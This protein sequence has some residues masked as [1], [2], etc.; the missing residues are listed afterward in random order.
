MRGQAPPV[1]PESRGPRA[2]AATR[3]DRREKVLEGSKA[4]SK[5]RV[6][7]L[8]ARRRSSGLPAAVGR[9]RLK[10]GRGRRFRGAPSGSVDL[11]REAAATRRPTRP[12][13]SAAAKARSG[14]EVRRARRRRGVGRPS[15]VG[16]ALPKIRHWQ[17]E[18]GAG[19]EGNNERYRRAHGRVLPDTKGIS[20]RFGLLITDSVSVGCPM[21]GNFVCRLPLAGAR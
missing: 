8:E 3:G 10:A 21:L 19:A 11:A 7:A 9:T 15:A 16:A 1:H 17:A 5:G 2:P 14:R 12:E 4:D 6:D 13:N 20:D 18:G